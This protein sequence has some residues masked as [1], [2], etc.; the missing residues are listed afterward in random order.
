MAEDFEK[1][2]A[3]YRLRFIDGAQRRID[4]GLE[5]VKAHTAD[6][7]RRLADELRSLAGEASILGLDALASVARAGADAARLWAEQ[8][9]DA[10]VRVCEHS[11]H[12]LAD[13]VALLA[14]MTTG[15]FT[16]EAERVLAGKARSTSRDA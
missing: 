6:N 5:L 2:R 12:T 11:L 14:E 15:D 16:R 10:A 1:L 13:T 4:A 3:R 8:A 9:S 7:A